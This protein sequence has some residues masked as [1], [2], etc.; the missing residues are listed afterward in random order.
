L[1]SFCEK[2]VRDRCQILDEKCFRMREK[3][4]CDFKGHYDLLRDTRKDT[5]IV[6]EFKQGLL[7]E[8][9]KSWKKFAQSPKSGLKRMTG[10]PL[11]EAAR[12]TIK[13]E[14][15]PLGVTVYETG[16]KIPIWKGSVNIIADCLAEKNEI[17]CICSVK[18]WIGEESLRETFA[19]AYFAKMWYGHKNVRVY[20]LE[21]HP[22]WP[23]LKDLV[24][25]CKPYIDGV[26][27]LS[28]SPYIDEL[29]QELR[30]LYQ[31]GS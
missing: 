10:G 28:S 12:K 22:I 6:K 4:K 18:S 29:L 31:K 1:K 24:V 23:N 5:Q 11:E 30:Y 26:Y 16:R 14:L 8:V 7:P 27:S 9:L 3:E 19:Y 21:L 2:L 20:M 13:K 25:A 17:K 15:E